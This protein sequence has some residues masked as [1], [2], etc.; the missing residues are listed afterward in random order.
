ML[1]AS[2]LLDLICSVP[3]A[4]VFPTFFPTCGPGGLLWHITSVVSLNE[5]RTLFS[6][7]FSPIGHK[8]LHK[9]ITKIPLFSSPAGMPDKENISNNLFVSVAK[10]QN[11]VFCTWHTWIIYMI[12]FCRIM[13]DREVVMVRQCCFIGLVLQQS[14]TVSKRFGSF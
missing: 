5:N 9:Y 2:L 6:V 14:V 10:H 4:L 8:L 3:Y 12:Q 13:K 7:I 1:S 11:K